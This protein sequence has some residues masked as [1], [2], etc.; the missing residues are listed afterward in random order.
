MIHNQTKSQT[1][2]IIDR[3]EELLDK[4]EGQSNGYSQSQYNQ[5]I[6]DEHLVNALATSSKPYQPPDSRSS[7]D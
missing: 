4:S 3:I 5:D 6:I 7:T 1:H 2:L